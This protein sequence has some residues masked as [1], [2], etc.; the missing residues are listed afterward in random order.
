[1]ARRRR[2]GPGGRTRVTALGMLMGAMLPKVDLPADVSRTKTAVA[3]ATATATVN[4]NSDGTITNDVGAFIANWIYPNYAGIGALYDVKFAKSSGSALSSGPADD[5][6]V[7][8]NVQRSFT[9][10]A[11]SSVRQTIGTWSVSLTG[12]GSAID[13]ATGTIRADSS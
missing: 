8:M 9:N 4:F 3:P 5:T 1:P 11:A 2:G 13:T 6:Y 12:A 7:Q 10:Q